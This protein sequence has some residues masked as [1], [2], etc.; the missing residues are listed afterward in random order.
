MPDESPFTLRPMKPADTDVAQRL[1]TTRFGGARSTQEHWI[2]AALD[3]RH[4]A[5]G[6]VAVSSSNEAVVGISFLEVGTPDYTRQYLGLDVLDLNLPLADENGLFH[7]SCVRADWEGRGIGSAF[8][9]RRLDVLAERSVPRAFGIAWHRPHAVDSRVLFEK[10]DFT[11]LAT[12][13]RYYARTGSR[14]HCPACKGV[15]TCTASLY[16]RTIDAV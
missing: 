4:S 13:E 8:Y 12:V 2:E 14:K 3:P 11:R 5:T 1:W 9:D 15:C 10:Y 7:L 16:T 6:F